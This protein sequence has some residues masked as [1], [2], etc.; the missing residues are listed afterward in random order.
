[1]TGYQLSLQLSVAVEHYC[2]ARLTTLVAPDVNEGVQLQCRVDWLIHIRYWNSPS[3][4]P[5]QISLMDQ[6]WNHENF[7]NSLGMKKL[8]S[9]SSGVLELCSAY[10]YY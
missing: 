3:Q 10:K 1:M 7:S 9:Y 8:H 5:T 6:A 2:K 4:K